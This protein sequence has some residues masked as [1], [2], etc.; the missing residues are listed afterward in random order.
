[1][2]RS[3]E[4]IFRAWSPAASP[5]SQWAKPVLFTHISPGLVGADVAPIDC[6]WATPAES[7]DMAI[8]VDLP[9]DR[10]VALGLSLAEA[11]YQPV[12]LFNAVPGRAMTDAAGEVTAASNVAVDLWPAMRAI[13]GGANR[14]LSASIACSAPPAFLLDAD[15]R[16]GRIPAP[17]PGTFD[18]R[19]VSFP[20]D[21][22]S[23]S[24]LINHG[25][26]RAVLVQSTPSQS[27]QA[28][29]AH[30]LRRWQD[31]GIRLMRTSIDTAD[32]AGSLEAFMVDR[33][34]WYRSIWHHL[35]VSIGLRRNVLG[36]FGGLL[37]ET[38]GSGG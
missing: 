17:G 2:S 7:S 30:T 4:E 5:W 27:P 19:S 23:A 35:L 31:D 37:P 26:R 34:R 20:T 29:L 38:H 11:G 14:L 24:Y 3:R 36:G 16:T 18:N 22:P 8:V 32:G 9:A 12:P 28:D 15:R 13:V 1:M 21:F 33:P 10:S 25:V 6:G